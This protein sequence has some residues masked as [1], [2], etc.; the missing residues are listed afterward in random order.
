MPTN[1][2]L[3]LSMLLRSL[4]EARHHEHRLGQHR[5]RVGDGFFQVQL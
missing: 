5:V 1:R 2:H 3:L 4:Q